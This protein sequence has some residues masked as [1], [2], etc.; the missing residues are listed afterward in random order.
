MTQKQ[1]SEIGRM[2]SSLRKDR[3]GGRKKIFRP[4]PHCGR[5]F[6]T[7]DLREHRKTCTKEAAS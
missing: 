6:G 4:C 2:L 5:E 7:R 1:K 3:N